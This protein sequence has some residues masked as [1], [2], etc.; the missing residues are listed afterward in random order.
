[1]IFLCSFCAANCVKMC[2]FILL[3]KNRGA[4]P[5]AALGTFKMIIALKTLKNRSKHHVSTGFLLAAEEGFEPSHTE[6]ESAVLP[7]HNSANYWCS[8]EH[9]YYYIHFLQF[10]KPF[11]QS[12][13]ISTRSVF[14]QYTLEKSVDKV[15]FKSYNN[16]RLF[17]EQFADVLEQVDRHV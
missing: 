2:C 14:F 6:S 10:V 16:I 9:F 13:S 5:T 17:V 8:A 7:L 1:M 15:S 11:F 4:L 12:F 3:S